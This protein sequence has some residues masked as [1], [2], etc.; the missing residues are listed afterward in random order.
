MTM[1]RK[2]KKW[3]WVV[4]VVFVIFLSILISNSAKQIEKA[5]QINQLDK[6][7]IFNKTEQERFNG[8]AEEFPDIESIKC[9]EGDCSVVY[10]SFQTIPDDLEFVIRGNAA[11]LSKRKLEQVGVSHVTVIGT[12]NGQTILT[13]SANQGK[14]DECK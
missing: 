10:F 12:Y 2:I 7:E 6:R 14:V 3:H 9:F 5:P 1:E 11:T 8:V 13:C 4:A